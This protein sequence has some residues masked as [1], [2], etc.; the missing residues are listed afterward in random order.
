[1]NAKRIPILVEDTG[2]HEGRTITLYLDDG[3]ILLKKA[4]VEKYL[5]KV[6]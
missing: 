5:Y 3:R 6:K 4:G 1:L 2:G